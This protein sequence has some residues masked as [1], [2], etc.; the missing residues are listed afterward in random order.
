MVLVGGGLGW[1]TGSIVGGRPVALAAGITAGVNGAFGGVRRVYAWRS[2]AGWY[3]FVSDSTWA[4]L[5]TTLGNILNMLNLAWRNAAYRGDFSLRRNRHLFENGVALQRGF[6]FTLGCVTSN[7]GTRSGRPLE[8]RLELIDL[9][10][11]LHIWQ[12]RWFGPIYPAMYVA[13]ATGGTVVAVITW[14]VRRERPSLRAMIRTAAYYDNPFEYWAY[15]AQGHWED[16][17]ADP[18]LKWG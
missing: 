5:G 3:A 12:N 16:N 15:K 18:T 13:W 1:F 11:D 4:L 17:S 6:A 14:L 9:H 7:A 2:V 10:E 8:E